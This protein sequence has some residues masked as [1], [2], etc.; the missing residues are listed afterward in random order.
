MVVRRSNHW[1]QVNTCYWIIDGQVRN[2][3]VT[4]RCYIHKFVLSRVVGAGDDGVMESDFLNSADANE[5]C[6]HRNDQQDKDLAED[7]RR[8]CEADDGGGNEVE[9]DVNPV[10]LVKW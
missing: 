1:G 2:H 3:L 5:R 10:V 6:L 7:S 9:H 4:A 8:G